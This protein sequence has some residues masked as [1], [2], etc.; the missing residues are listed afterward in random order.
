MTNFGKVVN[1]FN[2]ALKSNQTVTNDERKELVSELDKAAEIF[3]RLNSK[4]F[5]TE[6]EQ[7][8]H[9]LKMDMDKEIVKK[10][11]NIIPRIIKQMK[12]KN[13]V[14]AITIKVESFDFPFPP[15]VFISTDHDQIELEASIIKPQELHY[16]FD[17]ASADYNNENSNQV[18]VILKTYQKII[19]ELS[20]YNWKGICKISDNFVIDFIK[21]GFL[22]ETKK[23]QE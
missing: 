10:T 16:E 13:E 18:D 17:A 21:P 19:S 20:Q 12:I 7:N 22:G 14:E 5:I 15:A 9:N 6:F 8:L 2:K 4:E 11:V 1:A 23:R 3:K